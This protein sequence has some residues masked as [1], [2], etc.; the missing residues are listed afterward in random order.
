M[1]LPKELRYTRE[2]EWVRVEGDG[3][4]AVVGI[5]DFAQQQLGD[6]IFVELEAEGSY[7]E[8]DAVFGTVEAVKTVSELFMPI[9]GRIIEINED[10]KDKPELVNQNPYEGGWMIRVEIQDA[11]SIDALMSA[12]D[13]AAHIG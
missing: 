8:K 6:I 5:T 2:H 3:Q 9:S 11:G 7:I 12:D 1:N 13:Y 10:I 4:T